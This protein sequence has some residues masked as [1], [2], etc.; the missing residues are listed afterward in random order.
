MLIEGKQMISTKI[1]SC[2]DAEL[3]DLDILSCN[4]DPVFRVGV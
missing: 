2:D 3:K 1:I 4:N